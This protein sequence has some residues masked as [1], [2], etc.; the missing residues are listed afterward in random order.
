M[1]VPGS[2]SARPAHVAPA[3]GDAP[4]N[5]VA[6]KAAAPASSP[7]YAPE[8]AYH[9]DLAA[10]QGTARHDDDGH[11]KY[12]LNRDGRITSGEITRVRTAEFLERLGMNPGPRLLHS[13]EGSPWIPQGQGYDAERHEILTSY[14]DGHDVM[15]SVQDQFT[16]VEARNVILEGKQPPAEIGSDMLGLMAFR[17]ENP[18]PNKGGGVATDGK[19]VYLA[20]TEAVYVYRRE[21]IDNAGSGEAV[22]PVQV[23][24]VEAG[25]YITVKDGQAY[26]GRFALNPAGPFGDDDN[27][28]ELY[29]Y[30]I[31]PDG[32][33]SNQSD[34]IR[35]PYN[36]QGLAV[37]DDGLLFTTSY[38]ASPLSPHHLV[39]QE[40]D[41]SPDGVESASDAENV[42]DLDYYAEG[43]NIIGD[44]MWVT[45]ESSA[46]KYRDKVDRPR[47]HI[48]RIPL[49][50]LD[51]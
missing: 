14:N 18:S 7:P 16:G 33:F 35:T 21:D 20:D 40:F 2:V 45:Y 8:P 25:S 37:T 38:G 51:S 12:D 34:P 23:N 19:F 22:Y 31:N 27:V 42:Y 6:P 36:A 39:L 47:D 50:D 41:D 5:T 48:Q 29:R 1:L 17:E 4:A 28:P 44:E 13:G 9:P 10:L 15:L 26:V 49:D 43:V 24:K 30:D 3:D 11:E 32:T 46:E